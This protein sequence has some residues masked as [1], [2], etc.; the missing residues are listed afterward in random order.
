[1]Q[2]LD[3]CITE[4]LRL[5]AGPLVVREVTAPSFT[6]TLPSGEALRFRQG[7]RLMLFPYFQHHDPELFPNPEAFQH[8]RFV[9][10]P[11]SY[12]KAGYS[13]P[14][15]AAVM[16]FG[17]GATYCPGRKFA[18]NEIKTI[19]AYLLANFNV[20]LA[21]PS[22]LGATDYTADIDYGRV[23]TGT[24]PPVRGVTVKISPKY[25]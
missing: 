24:F 22:E 20:S 3:S 8:D 10:P 16:P 1:M 23:G 4:T 6:F 21:D 7:D 5:T 13:V 15:S 2:V 12:R 25:A 17:G 14:F 19:A 11:L 18:R 9:D